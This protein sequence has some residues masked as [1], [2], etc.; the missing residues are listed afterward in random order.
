MMRGGTE[1]GAAHAL[2]L[3]STSKGLAFQRRTTAGGI[4]THTSG[5]TGT[6][7]RWLRLKRAGD[8]ITASVSADGTTWTTVAS[9]TISMPSSVLVGLVV[10]S[11][12]TATL[13]TGTFDNVT[14]TDP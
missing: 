7:P 5:G 4:T 8:V 3:V 12:D 11:H 6:A 13:A 2:M 14:V 1:A 9:D 10:S